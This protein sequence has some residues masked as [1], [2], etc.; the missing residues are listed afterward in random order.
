M[1]KNP[2]FQI[3]VNKNKRLKRQ[4]NKK[5]KKENAHKNGRKLF[6]FMNK[7]NM[8]YSMFIP[9]I[10]TKVAKQYAFCFCFFFLFVCSAFSLGVFDFGS[11][12]SI[13]IPMIY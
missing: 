2:G 4:T 10:H 13:V 9:C 6:I 1:E 3:G 8:L 7:E 12:R 5:K 11:K